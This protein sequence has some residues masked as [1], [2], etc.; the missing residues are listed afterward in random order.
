ML[1]QHLDASSEPDI[2]TTQPLPLHITLG[3]KS[4]FFDN[5]QC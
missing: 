4:I 5:S 3:P 2:R 1:S